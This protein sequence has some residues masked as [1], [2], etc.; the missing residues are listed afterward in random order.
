MAML[1][2]NLATSPEP[3]R[4]LCLGAH[5]DDIEIG[6]GSTILRLLAEHPE[7]SVHWAVFSGGGG[8]RGAEARASAEDFLS[9]SG[10]SPSPHRITVLDF[11]DGFF[12]YQGAAVKDAFET[13]KA[14]TKPT[15]ILTHYKDDAHQDHRLIADLTYNTFRDHLILE[16][17]IPKYDGDLANPN[18]FIAV[19]E[20]AARRKIELLLRHFATQAERNWFTADTFWAL[21]RLRGTFPPA[22][23]GLAEAFYCRK[24]MI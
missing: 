23:E 12:P 11:R 24:A 10:T 16:Y 21:L 2:F 7:A 9:S 22:P 6:C 20:Q 4:I 5:P 8:P 19:S 15:I 13:I 3:P 14:T 18:L 1:Q 17:E